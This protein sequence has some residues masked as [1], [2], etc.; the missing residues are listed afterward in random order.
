MEEG[1]ELNLVTGF[2][3]DKVMT[4]LVSGD[5]GILVLWVLEASIY[6]YILVVQQIMLSIL[7]NSHNELEISWYQDNPITILL[8]MML[9]EKTILGGRAGGMPQMLLEYILKN[10]ELTLKTM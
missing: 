9:R 5:D 10:K 8:G 4:S 7:H 6:I 2:G 1:I 3:A